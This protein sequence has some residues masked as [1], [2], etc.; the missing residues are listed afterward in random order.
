MPELTVVGAGPAR[1][2]PGSNVERL[3]GRW[4]KC[5]IEAGRFGRSWSPGTA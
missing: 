1:W 4:V 5:R 2:W 3:G